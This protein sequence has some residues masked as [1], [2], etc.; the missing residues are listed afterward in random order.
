MQ[1]FSGAIPRCSHC[2]NPVWEPSGFELDD[3]PSDWRKSGRCPE[4]AIDFE[5][6]N[7]RRESA[8]ERHDAAVSARLKLSNLP[9]I[10]HDA[11]LSELERTIEREPLLD[12]LQKWVR[13]DLPS[14]FI[15]GPVGTGKTLMAAAAT[16]GRLE[17]KNVAW[18]T[19][20]RFALDHRAEYSSDASRRSQQLLE[21]KSDLVLDDLGQENPTSGSQE[22]LFAT[23]DDRIS[24]GA[25][26]L[27]TSNLAQSE[28]GAR[29]GM[30][31][32][33]RLQT[34]M[35]FRAPGADRRL[36]G[37]LDGR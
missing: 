5:H 9:A 21:S 16:R 7:P 17:R 23:I 37:A 34:M 35:A 29:Y 10:Y 15:C 1:A 13:G 27:I 11:R 14:L 32:P 36:Q 33:S 2:N 8:E 4:C 19:A 28:L 22:L 20:P 24:S 26:L 12:A 30:W 25:S 18:V 31:L 6:D 3:L